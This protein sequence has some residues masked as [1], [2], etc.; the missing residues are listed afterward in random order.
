[1]A[2]I[3]K[4]GIRQMYVLSH[5]RAVAPIKLGHRRVSEEM[6][7]SVW[8]Y[9]SLY[10]A[11]AL[12]LAVGMMAAGLDPTSAIGAVTASR[13]LLGPGPGEVA[14]TFA[15]VNA[16]VKWLAV[17]GMLVGRLEVFTLLIL[18]TPSFWRH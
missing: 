1:M 16:V 2:L 10:I 8:G 17:I 15:S 6:L 13:N 11:T 18:L 5:A 12:V 3:A 4:L 14:T 7:Y 9:Y